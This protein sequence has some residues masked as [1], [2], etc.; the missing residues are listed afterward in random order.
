[1]RPPLRIA[2]L[3]CDTPVENVDAKYDG[4]YGVF[5]LLLRESAK[6]LGSLGPETDF[7]ITRWD[8]VFK[9]EY[10]K[11]ED[12]DVILLTGSSK[13]FPTLHFNSISLYTLALWNYSL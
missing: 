5:S 3:E 13:L 4:Y 12:V 10:P 8:V 7:D 11:L 9:Q 1:M 6:A 2:I